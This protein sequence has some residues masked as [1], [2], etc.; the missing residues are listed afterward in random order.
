[1]ATSIFDDKALCPDGDMVD[2]VLEESRS[3]WQELCSHIQET[4]TNIHTEWK[5]YGK[6]SGWTL[7]YKKGKRTLLCLFPNASYF[8]VSFVFGEKAVTAAGQAPLSKGV[9]N[10]IQSAKVYMEGR[11]F[12]MDVRGGDDLEHVKR[13]L[14]IKVEN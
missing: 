6:S 8:K 9:I 4:Y 11:S 10:T 5:F 12:F 7:L 14:A 2:S 3:L 1:M 13:L